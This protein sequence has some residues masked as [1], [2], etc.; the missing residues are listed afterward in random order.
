MYLVK[1]CNKTNLVVIVGLSLIALASTF[2]F[3]TIMTIRSQEI[4]LATQNLGVRMS[5]Y[6]EALQ[7]LKNV[8]VT[9]IIPVTGILTLL[10]VVAVLSPILRRLAQ[11]FVTKSGLTIVEEKAVSP[12]DNFEEEPAVVLQKLISEEAN[13]VEETK[14]LESF[15]EKWELKVKKDIETRQKSIRKLRAEIADLKLMRKE[16]SKS[17]RIGV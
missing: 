6:E 16:L 7:R 5:L 17:S 1:K 9:T 10:G 3:F 13:L 8:Y 14:K 12:W 2:W 15:R 11:H 4:M